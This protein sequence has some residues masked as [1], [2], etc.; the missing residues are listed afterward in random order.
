MSLYV[1]PGLSIGLGVGSFALL[2]LLFLG[3]TVLTRKLTARKKK[4]AE[5]KILQTKSWATATTI[6]G[7]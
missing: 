1:L 2:L 7:S 6:G 3:T 5:R 4:K